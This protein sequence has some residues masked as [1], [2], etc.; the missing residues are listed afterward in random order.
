M[1]LHRYRLQRTRSVDCTLGSVLCGRQGIAGSDVV[2]ARWRFRIGASNR[3]ARQGILRDLIGVVITF[4]LRHC[5]FS[6]D[7]LTKAIR[8]DEKAARLV[9]RVTAR[10]LAF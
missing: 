2:L 3:I 5:C 7:N 6:R 10:L 4:G 1:I 9:L 8:L